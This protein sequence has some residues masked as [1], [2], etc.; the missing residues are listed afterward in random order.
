ML[1]LTEAN[2]KTILF[3]TRQKLKEYLGKEG[4]AV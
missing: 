4:Y 1:G 2:A 3:R